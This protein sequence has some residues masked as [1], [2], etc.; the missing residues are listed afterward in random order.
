M[1]S[2]FPT[3][4]CDRC[5]DHMKCHSVQVTRCG[6]GNR[7]TRSYCDACSVCEKCHFGTGA[8]LFLD[9]GGV[10][11]SHCIVKCAVKACA[12]LLGDTDNQC[13]A[14]FC[15]LCDEHLLT[16]RSKEE[17]REYAC[18]DCVLD[19]YTQAGERS[20]DGLV[21]GDCCRCG[22][23]VSVYNYISVKTFTGYERISCV[24]CCHDVYQTPPVTSHA[25]ALG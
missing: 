4:V 10:Y 20:G 17:A 13:S 5:G 19:V 7:A 9:H 15:N 24:D 22:R 12:N 25:P 1:A 16:V 2:V 6:A 3:S 18:L 23:N 8:R 21:A 11:C 14:C